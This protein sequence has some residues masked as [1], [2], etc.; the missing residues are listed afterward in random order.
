MTNISITKFYGADW[1]ADCKR[2][3]EFLDT[4]GITYNY[5]DIDKVPSAAD[6]VSEINNGFKSIPTLVF[7]NG[8]VLVEPSNSQLADML[9]LKA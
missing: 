2:S 5:I 8:E 9:S 4:N 1:C 7:S 3:R 6:E